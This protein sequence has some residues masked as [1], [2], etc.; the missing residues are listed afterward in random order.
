MYSAFSTNIHWARLS[1]FSASNH[2]HGDFGNCF[3][4]TTRIYHNFVLIRGLTES[5]NLLLLFP[6]CPS[7][8]L[9][10][11]IFNI[12]SQEEGPNVSGR[13]SAPGTRKEEVQSKVQYCKDVGSILPGRPIVD[14]FF[15]TVL[16][17]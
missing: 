10:R 8:S 9:R 7:C 16:Y 2:L 11:G 14:K 5:T 17:S 1:L 3:P 6:H 13:C 12:S 4:F 15:S